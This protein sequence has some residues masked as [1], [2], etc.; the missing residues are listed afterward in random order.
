MGNSSAIP[1]DGVSAA[2][3]ALIY[4]LADFRGQNF[5]GMT[6]NQVLDSVDLSHKAALQ[7]I[8][9]TNNLGDAKILDTSWQAGNAGKYGSMSAATFEVDGKLFVAYQG[10][11]D[12]NWPYNAD[13]AYGYEASKMQKWASQYFDDVM[14]ARYQGQEV[15]VTGHSQGGN[16]AMYTALFS[17]RRDCITNYISYDGPGFSE[18][19]LNQARYLNGE[20][21][22]ELI[23]RKGYAINGK[24]DFVHNLGEAHLIP[25]DRI[26]FVEARMDDPSG[27]HDLFSHFDE[28]GALGDACDEGAISKLS[29]ELNNRFLERLSKEDRYKAGRVVMKIVDNLRQDGQSI[30][31]Q[32]EEGELENLGLIIPILAELLE[33][34]PELLEAALRE[35]GL[36]PRDV[37]AI[38]TVIKEFNKLSPELRVQALTTLADCIEVDEEGYL[39]FNWENL[40]SLNDLNIWTTIS[41]ALPVIW[42]T[43]VHHPDQLADLFFLLGFDKMIEEWLRDNPIAVV[44]LVIA[45]PFVIRMLVMHG[46]EIAVIIAIVDAV[47][48]I[49]S[50]LIGV[51][52]AIA[53]FVLNV[54][55]AIMQAFAQIGEWLF[56]NSA[57]Y[58]YAQ[59]NPY[60]RVDTD[61]LR[62]YAQRLENLN[63]RLVQLDHDMDNLYPQ[64][65]LTDLISV[66]SV[67]WSTS[68][69]ITLARAAWD[70]RATADELDAAENTAY[71]YLGG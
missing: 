14:D 6:L 27:T 51:A 66:F 46:L 4:D 54:L 18:D 3:S 40:F 22:Y 31:I 21:Y 34:K 58:R 36:K 24:E 9:E 56:R 19:L 16:D 55:G 10:T 63:W 20:E 39:V 7:S 37:D 48:H 44:A 13:S 11:A 32:F 26:R 62:S 50:G 52:A 60:F 38:V 70:I 29:T 33:E 15:Y 41:T 28:N 61:L 5:G 67:N 30:T 59:Q 2:L 57:G 35:S 12:G 47:C 68:W 45:V 43:A 49:V 65:R 71:G 42:E 69:S 17:E 25:E 1:Y 8:I 53:E 64:V 23:R